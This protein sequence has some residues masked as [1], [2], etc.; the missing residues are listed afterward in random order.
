[1]GQI[2]LVVMRLA[3]MQRVHPKQDNSRVCMTCGE[4]VGI[5]PSGQATLRRYPSVEIVCERC[6]GN[7]EDAVPAPGAVAEASESVNKH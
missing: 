3:D 5:F 6:H 1:M 2:T 4:V 7:V